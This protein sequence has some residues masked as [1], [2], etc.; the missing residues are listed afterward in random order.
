MISNEKMKINC[1][2]YYHDP[3]KTAVD[4]NADDDEEVCVTLEDGRMLYCW[5]FT[6]E[7]IKTIMMRHQ[8]SGES[9]SGTFFWATNMIIISAINKVT[10][11]AT[12]KYL[13][14]EKQDISLFDEI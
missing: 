10:M 14:E 12:L 11:E 4:Y 9:N 2:S 13:I 7:K 6:L 1:I 3:E 5:F 8:M